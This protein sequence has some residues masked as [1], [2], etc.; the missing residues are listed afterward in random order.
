[1]RRIFIG[2]I[3]GCARQLEALI[4]RLQVRTG[5]RIYCVGDLVNR[6][7]DSLHVLRY[8]R[9][10]DAQLVLGNHELHL[11]RIAAG[12]T[13]P[14]DQDR[15]TAVLEA[16]DRDEMLAW[17]VAQPVLRVEDDLIVVHAGV[18]PAWTDIA[19]VAAALNAAV[20]AYIHGSRDPWIEF[21]TTVRYC[22]LVGRRPPH[23]DPPPQPPFMPWDHF[24]RGARTVVFGH[25]ARRGFV[26][27][28]RCLGLD[29]GCV[30]GGHL[31]AWVA[32]EDRIVQVPGWRAR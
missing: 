9:A 13:I 27:H 2:D 17:L 6:G 4:Q 18:H 1:M 28:T 11:L 26:R 8:A 5:D 10:L 24:Y 16:P 23:D 7:P 19:A 30:Y 22:D 15:F 29:T 12:S 20:P 21:A 31:T 25:W 3:Q 32:E 14:A